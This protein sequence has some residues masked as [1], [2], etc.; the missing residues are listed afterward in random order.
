[1][2]KTHYS[3][4]QRFASNVIV[5]FNHQTLKDCSVIKFLKIDLVEIVRIDRIEFRLIIKYQFLKGYLVKI[6]TKTKILKTFHH[7]RMVFKRR[8]VVIEDLEDR[9][10]CENNDAVHDLGRIWI[11]HVGTYKYLYL[12]ETLKILMHVIFLIHFDSDMKNNSKKLH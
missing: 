10:L 12:H 2:R 9:F 3:N 11:K 6:F 7:Y 4:S 5:K 8:E 1:M